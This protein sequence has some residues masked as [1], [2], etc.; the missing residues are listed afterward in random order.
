VK[1]SILIAGGT[2]FIGYHLSKKCL[3][4]GWNVTSISTSYPKKEKK[5]HGVNY[6]LA[7]LSKKKNLLRIK[8]NFNY[9]VN[10]SGYV[11]HSNKKKTLDSHYRGCQNLANKFVESNIKKFIQIGSCIEYGKSKSP[12]LE[13]EKNLNHTYSYY[14]KA[15]LM[16]TKHLLRL[17]KEKSFPV[18]IIRLY[19][20]YGPKQDTNRVIPITIHNAMKNK[21]FKCS[22][23]SQLRDFIF[24]DDVITAIIKVLKNKESDGEIF[25]IGTRKPIKIKY[26]INKI[27]SILGSGSPVFGKIKF[28]KDEIEKLYPNINKAKKI[29]RWSPKTSLIYGLKKTIRYYKNEKYN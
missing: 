28:R 13:N 21:K 5:I 8:K 7:D 14:G 27:C 6:V 3:K 22:E 4:L 26:L 2:G 11:D 29:L 25:N 18:T 15:K 16:S 12:Q 1:K 10:L 20:V 19:L 24:I 23:G 17:Y 9:V